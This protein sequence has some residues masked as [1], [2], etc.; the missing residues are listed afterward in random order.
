[1]A[2]LS[3]PRSS[4]LAASAVL[5]T[6]AVALLP[7]FVGPSVPR[8]ATSAPG[9]ARL[10]GAA[11]AAASARDLQYEGPKQRGPKQRVPKQRGPKQGAYRLASLGQGPET[12]R[13]WARG[14]PKTS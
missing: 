7:A 1:M 5:A 8:V 13:F 11:P 3:R 10:R 2:V 12:K 4:V 14:P 9:A 6:V